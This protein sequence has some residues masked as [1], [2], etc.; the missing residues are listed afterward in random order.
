M[1]CVGVTP[2]HTPG[3][4]PCAG[5][6]LGWGDGGGCHHCPSAAPQSREGHTGERRAVAPGLYLEKNLETLP[7][8]LCERYR[9]GG[10][11]C[12]R[13]LPPPSSPPGS[14]RWQNPAALL[15]SRVFIPRT[16]NDA[17]KTLGQ[18]FAC[19]SPERSASPRSVP[20]PLPASIWGATDTQPLARQP[21][22]SKHPNPAWVKAS[23]KGSN[24]VPAKFA[25]FA[26]KKK[27]NSGGGGSCG[28]WRGVRESRRLSALLPSRGPT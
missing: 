15:R 11:G 27:K 26:L 24:F 18:T 21:K 7:A 22:F 6:S 5:H 8:N 14:P 1:F 23:Q 16:R 28:P 20:P 4:L 9:P 19:P 2:P 12:P 17:R 25:C 13:G 10:R 3:F